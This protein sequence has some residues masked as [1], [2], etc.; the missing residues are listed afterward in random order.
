MADET[1]YQQL[2]S[3]SFT[4]GHWQ[5]QN[6]AAVAATAQRKVATAVEELFL[7]A[8]DAVQ[9]FNSYVELARQVRI[10]RMDL[11]PESAGFVL[12][13]GPN[14]MKVWQ[15]GSTLHVSLTL[16][17]RF[18]TKTVP[19]YVFA[20]EFDVFGAVR[21]RHASQEALSMSSLVQRLMQDLCR[22]FFEVQRT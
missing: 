18:Q 14:Q 19:L 8:Q 16:Q 3:A 10:L 2:A 15:Q 4:G 13:L 9:L 21:W 5:L 11:D 20:P 7:E 17:I 12:L 22:A 6:P 1:W